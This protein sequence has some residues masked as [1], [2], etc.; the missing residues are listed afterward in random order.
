[1]SFNVIIVDSDMLISDMV[2][3]FG[4]G[5]CGDYFEVKF[6]IDFYLCLFCV[7]F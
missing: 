1:M 7:V 6:I 4:V 3:V 5:I 2:F